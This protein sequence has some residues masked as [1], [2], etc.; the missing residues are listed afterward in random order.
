MRRSCRDVQV[1]GRLLPCPRLVSTEQWQPMDAPAPASPRAPA[2]DTRDLQL[3]HS[4]S[5]ILT[6]PALPFLPHPPTSPERLAR[7]PAVDNAASSWAH[8]CEPHVESLRPPQSSTL[9]STVA[10]P[11]TTA[12]PA[13]TLDPPF[14]LP[15][16]QRFRSS[17]LQCRPTKR[18]CQRWCPAWPK[19]RTSCWWRHRTRQ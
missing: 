10:L 1:G 14:K 11:P 17:H 12:L 16:R 3:Q 8:A 15:C 6:T 4:D 9:D 19:S 18:L 2:Y 7:G 5:A 13:A